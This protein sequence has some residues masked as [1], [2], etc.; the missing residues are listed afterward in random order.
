MKSMQI[1]L[2]DNR[3]T[4]RGLSLKQLMQYAWGNVGVGEGL[5]ASLIS[6]GPGWVD[7]DRFDVVAKAEGSRVASR[8][9]RRQMLRELL[10]ERFQIQIHHETRA[11]AVYALV[12]AKN[13]PKMK[14][15][16]P[17]DGGP[18]FSLAFISD[19]HITG[20][21]VPMTTLVD[22]LQGILPL[23]DTEHDNR[24]VVDQT[25]L[26]GRFDFELQWS[27]DANF[28]GGRGRMSA[29]TAHAPELFTAVEEQLGLR[30]EPKKAPMETI[31]IDRAEK[32][33]DN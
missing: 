24:P 20:R 18:P 16:R 31:V 30:L 8:A 27:G 33:T 1:P 32:P 26:T 22:V 13:G 15:R 9:E 5:H 29:E 12:V 3:L 4:I 28:A 23:T 2:D 10:M 17:D 7:H 25:G 6:G 14:A 19:L 21:N 11:L